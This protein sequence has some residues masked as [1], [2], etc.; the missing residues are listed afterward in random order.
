MNDKTNSRIFGKIVT[1]LCIVLA[2][3]GGGYF[4]LDKVVVP[5]YFGTYGIHG[6]PDLVGVVTSLYKSPKESK[7]VTNGYTQVDLSNAIDKLQQANY[8]I[9]DDGVITEENM[10]HFKGSE[11]LKLTDKEFAAVCNKL[12][13]NG[14]LNEALPNL[15][16]LNVLNIT[17]LQVVI[18]PT[19]KAVVENNKFSQAHIGFIVKIDTDDIREQIAIQMETPVFLLNMIIPDVLYF[20]VSYDFDLTKEEGERVTNGSIAINNRTS[21][22]SEILINLL[23]DFIFPTEDEMNLTK[24]TNEVGKIALEGVDALGDFTFASK[25]GSLNNEYGLIVNPTI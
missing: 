7:F 19:E 23:I 3:F 17:V 4:L 12:I 2:I 11:E 24:F 20:E 15:N 21:K 14:M 22:Q 13:E 9:G 6:V 25:L 5:K 8:Q 10:K 16:Y 1:M 18:N